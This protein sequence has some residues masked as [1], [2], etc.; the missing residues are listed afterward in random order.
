MKIGRI[1]SSQDGI[2]HDT[3]GEI[4]CLSSGNGNVPKILINEENNSGWGNYNCPT[5]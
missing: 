2:I 4:Q 3:N 5:W 1:N